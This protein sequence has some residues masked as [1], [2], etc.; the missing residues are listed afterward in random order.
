MVGV[1]LEHRSIF[2]CLLQKALTW[3]QKPAQVPLPSLPWHRSRAPVSP[4]RALIS[5]LLQPHVQSLGLMPKVK[6]WLLH[7]PCLKRKREPWGSPALQS[8]PQLTLATL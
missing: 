3:P 7:P 2:L 1:Q 4:Q 8:Q 6:N 5:H